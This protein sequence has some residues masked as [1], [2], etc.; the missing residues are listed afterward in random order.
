MD[1][2]SLQEDARKK[3]RF[4]LLAFGLAVAI[5]VVLMYLA[6]TLIIAVFH[7]GLPETLYGYPPS[8]LAL[9]PFLMVSAVFIGVTLF[10]SYFKIKAIRE[11]GGLYM[12]EIM[13]AEL[14]ETPRDPRETQL[15]NVVEEMSVAS[16]LPRPSLYILRQEMTINAVTGGLDYED[17]VIVVTQ[18][19]LTHLDREELQA[20]MA[21]EFAHIINGDFSLNLT[22]AGWLYG[23]LFLSITGEV[24][25]GKTT[26]I[27]NMIWGDR[28][29][30]SNSGDQAG[31]VL[32]V[33]GGL[34]LWL[35]GL[36]LVI[37]GWLSQAAARVVQA[38]FSRQR[39]FL[40][41]A[42]AVQFTRNP[43]GLA[44]ALKKIASFP[45]RGIIRGTNAAMM[46]AFFI[47]SPS[48]ADGLMRTHPPLE[49][50]ILALEPDWDGTLPR[51]NLYG[52]FDWTPPYS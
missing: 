45:R 35:A 4:F 32:L 23:L 1:F 34:L 13:G 52:G 14:M 11:G 38:A 3:S 7:G 22:M 27:V 44:G 31:S 29:A 6:M 24:L 47:V 49:D 39:E 18:G 46:R 8:F 9:K 20:V 15:L 2:F 50:R 21:H 40:A 19:A 36:A 28:A 12:A 17:T 25:M 30:N 41:D 5:T 33:F 26:R 51:L 43:A 37:C 16:G 48:K 10:A 42:S